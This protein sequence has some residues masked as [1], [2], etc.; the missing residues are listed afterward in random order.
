ML[1]FLTNSYHQNDCQMS[2]DEGGGDS[3]RYM[4]V[5][6]H[7]SRYML[8]LGHRLAAMT[9]CG[10][11]GDNLPSG[12]GKKQKYY[13]S[14]NHVWKL[15]RSNSLFLDLK[16]LNYYLLGCNVVLRPRLVHALGF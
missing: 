1:L 9:W 5:V 6:V 3:K 15:I 12:E 2:W 13:I 14:T 8:E 7:M 10:A 4:Q 11:Y 16:R